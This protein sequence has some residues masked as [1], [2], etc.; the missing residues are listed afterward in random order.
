MKYMDKIETNLG[1]GMAVAKMIGGKLLVS[2][3]KDHIRGRNCSGP[4]LNVAMKWCEAK[5]IWCERN[6]CEGCEIIPSTNCDEE[7]RGNE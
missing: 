4:C 2:I 7:R 3:A 6:G 1:P 5:E